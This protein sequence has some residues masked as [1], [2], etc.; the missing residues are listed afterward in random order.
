MSHL[1][2]LIEAQD[3]VAHTAGPAALHF[4]L[5]SEKLLASEASSIVQLSVRQN[6]QQSA[7]PCIHIAHHSHPGDQRSNT[8]GELDEQAVTEQQLAIA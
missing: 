4:M 7:L 8:S 3:V 1:S 6:P 5:V 2:L